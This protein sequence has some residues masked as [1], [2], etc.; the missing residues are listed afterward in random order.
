VL[1][2]AFHSAVE[3]NDPEALAA[4]LADDVVFRSPVTF[5]A[6][7]GKPLVVTILTEG[8]MKV[9]S[10]FRYTDRFESD[11]SAALIFKARVGDREV[12]GL[13][14]LRFDEDGRVRELM[15]MV[16]P[17]SGVHALAEAMGKRFEGLGLAPAGH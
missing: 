16:R 17:M 10:D 2:D 9:F 8:A 13:D 5:N 3:A 7:E 1:S 6:Y 12:D 14:L 4:C 11:G 15:V